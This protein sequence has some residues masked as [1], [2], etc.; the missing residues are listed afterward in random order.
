MLVNISSFNIN[1]KFTNNASTKYYEDRFKNDMIKED[2]FFEN[3][4]DISLC[5]RFYILV[6]Q[7]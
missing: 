7:S 3:P 2:F 4:K 6:I 1:R 5:S